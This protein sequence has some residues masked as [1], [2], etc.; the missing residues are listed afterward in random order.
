MRHIETSRLKIHIIQKYEWMLINFRKLFLIG[1]MDVYE[2][3]ESMRE[4][5]DQA[6]YLGRTNARS[7]RAKTAFA[8]VI[9]TSTAFSKQRRNVA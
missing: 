2:E 4:N 3:R 9:Y 5:T 6:L 7:C 1:I 8:H